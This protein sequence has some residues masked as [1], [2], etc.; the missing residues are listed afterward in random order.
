VVKPAIKSIP[1]SLYQGGEGGAVASL[2]LLEQ[3]LLL[4]GEKASWVWHSHGHC[5]CTLDSR[6]NIF[7]HDGHTLWLS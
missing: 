3:A 7:R 4:G 1:V 5:P 6:P 2:G